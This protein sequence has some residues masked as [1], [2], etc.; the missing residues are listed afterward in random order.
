M[1]VGLGND[2]G[3]GTMSIRDYW[4]DSFR[5]GAWDSDACVRRQA[6]EKMTNRRLLR[7][8]AKHDDVHIVYEAAMKRLVELGYEDVVVRI[9]VDR[10]DESNRPV[11]AISQI[12]DQSVLAYTALKNSNN[13][14]REAAVSR[15]RDQNLLKKIATSD[16]NARVRREAATRIEDKETLLKIATGDRSELVRGSAASEIEDEE[17]LIR[18]ANHDA[19]KHV[20]IIAVGGIADDAVL[21]EIARKDVHPE[22]RV[23]AR[24]RI[25]DQQLRLASRSSVSSRK[26]VHGLVL[27][28]IEIGAKNYFLID[29]PSKNAS[30]AYDEDLRHRRAVRIGWLL[31]EAGGF[32]LMQEAGERVR[33]KLGA[34]DARMLEVAWG[35]I[36]EWLA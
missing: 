8:I 18:I 2:K 10:E 17:T 11:A 12:T 30:G 1:R 22:V 29:S 24:D 4:R 35:G 23:A 9:A 28:L 19:S 13:Y 31:H 5:S 6:T 21:A 33:S 26:Q 27:E 15:L 3:K 16:K 14:R 36:G 7:S 34:L 32:R 25:K 20:R